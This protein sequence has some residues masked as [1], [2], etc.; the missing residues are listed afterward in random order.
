MA[1]DHSA[2]IKAFFLASDNGSDHAAYV[3]NFTADATLKMGLKTAVGSEQIRA[4][5]E[6]M[7][8]AV[9]SRH[10][11]VTTTYPAAPGAEEDAIMMFGSVHYTLTNGRSLTTEWSSRMV[12]D[13]SGEKLKFYQ[14]YLDASPMIVALGKRIE[15]DESGN[16]KVV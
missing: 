14:V 15:A 2:F 8:A 1:R 4:L 12:F 10:H 11:V 6:G 13:R 7:W 9:T 5:R 16:V 3:E